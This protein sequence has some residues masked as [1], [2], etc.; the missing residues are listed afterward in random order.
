MNFEKKEKPYFLRRSIAYLIDIIIVTL[1]ATVISMIFID[2]TNYQKKSEELMQ[3]TKKYTDGEITRE[4]YSK[5]FD[6]LNY[7]VTKEG[8]GT[9][10]ANCSVAIV[11]YVILCYF[12]HGITLGKYIMKLPFHRVLRKTSR[13]MKLY[14]I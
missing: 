4:E 2:N 13:G 9:T 8:I 6:T 14:Y 11:Y 3:L 10:I 5:E 7:Y 12:C 1:L